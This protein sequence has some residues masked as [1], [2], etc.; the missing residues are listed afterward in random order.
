MPMTSENDIG[1]TKHNIMEL[2]VIWDSSN[3]LQLPPPAFMLLVVL[4]F[5]GI[6]KRSATLEFFIRLSGIY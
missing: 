2:K 3:Y 1:K 4:P 6:C 5:F